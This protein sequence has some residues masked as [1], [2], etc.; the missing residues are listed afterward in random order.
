M[1]TDIVYAAYRWKSY[2]HE[3]LALI[4]GVSLSAGTYG[5]LLISNVFEPISYSRISPRIWSIFTIIPKPPVRILSFLPLSPLK[6]LPAARAS[7]DP[8]PRTLERVASM[9]GVAVTAKKANL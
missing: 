9:N 6:S 8:A 4:G 3:G 2:S 1:I 5:F 7:Y